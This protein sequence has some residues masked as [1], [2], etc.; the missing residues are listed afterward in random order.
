MLSALFQTVKY[1]KYPICSSFLFL[2]RFLCCKNCIFSISSPFEIYYY[3]RI[4]FLL[5]NEAQRI[6][7]SLWFGCNL[8]FRYSNAF[9]FK[10]RLAACSVSLFSICSSSVSRVLLLHC[11]AQRF[12]QKRRIE[13]NNNNGKNNKP[14]SKKMVR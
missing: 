9:L 12:I 2:S 13:W 1:K 4:L 7:L 14:N 6:S 8:L 10:R 3:L 11:G 5:A